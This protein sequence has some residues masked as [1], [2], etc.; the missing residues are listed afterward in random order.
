MSEE[1]RV[2]A[3]CFEF[4]LRLGARHPGT[5]HVLYLSWQLDPSI[6]THQMTGVPSGAIIL[7]QEV[8]G[9]HS[10]AYRP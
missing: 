5:I 1:H 9:F 10:A 3:A 8:I 4:F 6:L 7:V 2:T